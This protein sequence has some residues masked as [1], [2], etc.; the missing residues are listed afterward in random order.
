[1]SVPCSTL[2]VA[3]GGSGVVAEPCDPAF[4][5][6]EFPEV[7]GSGQALLGWAGHKH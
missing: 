7:L 3:G 5:F 4:A 6:P 2:A 1:M